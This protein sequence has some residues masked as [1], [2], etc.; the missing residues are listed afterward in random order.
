MYDIKKKTQYFPKY[1]NF[2][3]QLLKMAYI[4]FTHII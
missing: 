2:S 4:T 3:S 1:I